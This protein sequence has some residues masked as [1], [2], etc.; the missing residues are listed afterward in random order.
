MVKDLN[1]YFK[2]RVLKS[3][4]QANK[5]IIR[6]YE[7]VSLMN[8]ERKSSTKYQ[9]TEFS[10]MLK[11]IIHHDQAKYFYLKLLSKVQFFL[12]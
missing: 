11:R 1:R 5:D 2:K 9:R 3:L 6:N 10:S 7:S 8:I 12:K 4:I